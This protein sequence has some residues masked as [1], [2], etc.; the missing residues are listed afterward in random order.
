MDVVSICIPTYNG[1]EYLE[2]CIESAMRQSYEAIEILLVDD[3]SGDDTVA[4]CHRL[5]KQDSRIRV[6][7]NEVNLGLVGNWNRCIELAQGQWIKFLFQDDL[8]HPQCVAKLMREAQARRMKFIACQ[9]D[10]LF[11]ESIGSELRAIYERNRQVIH[12]FLMPSRGATPSEFSTR[13]VNRINNN[14]VGEP[15]S[16]LIHKSVFNDYGLFNPE[17]T[18]LCD[19]EFWVR[20]ASHEGV[21]FVPEPLATFRVH[22]SAT[23]AVNRSSKEFR[24]TALDG[25]AIRDLMLEAPV[26]KNLRRLWQEA[27]LLKKM[28]TERWSLAN[29][30][31]QYAHRH[32]GTNPAHQFIRTEYLAF[33]DR[34]PRCRVTLR[35]HL[36]WLLVVTPIRYKFRLGQSLNP[37]LPK[38]WRR[39][40]VRPL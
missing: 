8:L 29:E 21:A 28:R 25:L 6:V 35:Q 39:G 4:I 40:S 2:Q 14:Y 13:I 5:A 20:L 18:Q 19:L 38:A 10:F 30:V 11:D 32:R 17:L 27:S 23:S 1:V 16:V 12:D 26:Y 9:R 24:A 7:Q 36:G 22:G 31:R 3:K 37:I 34:H 33:L 15:T